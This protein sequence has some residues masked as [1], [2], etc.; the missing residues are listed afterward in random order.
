M[1]CD[2]TMVTGDSNGNVQFWDAQLGTRTAA[3]KVHAADVLALAASPEGDAVFAAGVDPQLALYKRV[4]GSKGEP[5]RCRSFTAKQH[6]MQSTR[7]GGPVS[8]VS[9]GDECCRWGGSAAGI[10]NIACQSQT[11]FVSLPQ[12]LDFPG[13]SMNMLAVAALLDGGTIFASGGHHLKGEMTLMPSE[14]T[15][16]EAR[17]LGALS[18]QAPAQP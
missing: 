18:V 17:A 3:F 11:S 12:T 1:L 7:C 10:L 2:G 14:L 4:P 9:G 16:R 5:A 6:V 15:C 13:A 8:G